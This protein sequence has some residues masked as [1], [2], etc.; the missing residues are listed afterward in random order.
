M[1]HQEFLNPNTFFPLERFCNLSDENRQ[2][3]RELALP[4]LYL[5]HGRGVLIGIISQLLLMITYAELG[6]V[7]YFS[8]YRWYRQKPLPAARVRKNS[9]SSLLSIIASQMPQAVVL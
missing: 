2:G 6:L 8:S 1:V 5:G 4:V 9:E 3:V 7:F